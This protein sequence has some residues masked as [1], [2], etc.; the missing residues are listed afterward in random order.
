MT[1]EGEE[2]GSVEAGRN[3]AAGSVAF[4]AEVGVKE[5]VV[6]L[7]WREYSPKPLA[8]GTGTVKSIT[9]TAF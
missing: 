3:T 5:L 4:I 9:G 7:P 1:G 8:D 2:K 6:V